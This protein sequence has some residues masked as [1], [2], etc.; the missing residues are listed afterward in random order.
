VFEEGTFPDDVRHDYDGLRVSHR[1]AHNVYG[2]QMARATYE[3]FVRHRKERRPF[4]L[5]RSG[6]AGVQRYTALWTGDNVSA[7]EHL[8]IANMQCQRLSVSG[9]SFAGT[10][11][12]GF[13]GPP[14]GELF[15]RYIQLAVFHPFFRGHA[16]SDS[17]EK[18]PW[19]FGELYAGPIRQAIELRYRLLPYLYSVF[20]Q[21]V[22]RGTPVL[23]P[24]AF[25]DPHD[26]HTWNRMDEFCFGDLLLV[27]PIQAKG[28]TG[29]TLYLPRGIWY[30]YWTGKTVKGG[31]ERYVDAPLHVIP[32]F[33]KAGAVLPHA[34]VRQHTGEP[35]A[36]TVLHVYFTMHRQRSSH[37]EDAG[38]GYGYAGG[39]W[40]LRHYAVFGNRSQLRIVQRKEGKFQ[41]GYSKVRLIVEGLPFRP[42]KAI[43]DGREIRV[44]AAP[45]S[46]QLTL[47][48]DEGFR[49][50]E[51][52]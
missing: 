26:P 30:N 9:V 12:G 44:S 16:A 46:R 37:Y 52:R 19:A 13:T 49:K 51:I 28:A 1:K 15:T 6:F 22:T 31:H 32:L 39:D 48:A 40:L 50:I 29:R 43:V 42:R 2:M 20:H 8:W 17:G 35:V 24:L 34:P 4:V 25:V 5:S 3:G 45:R 41:P 38:E 47:E 27:C 7:W 33:V 18:E 21:Y 11:I 14:D 10:D 23:R 36:E